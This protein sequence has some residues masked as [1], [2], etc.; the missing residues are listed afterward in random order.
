MNDVLTEIQLLNNCS[1]LC[2]LE[3]P[4]FY[5][6]EVCEIVKWAERSRRKKY[7]QTTKLSDD[8]SATSKF[9]DFMK[10]V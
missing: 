4:L 5:A 10:M 1:L 3:E 7:M 2:T 9:W 6:F 8:Q